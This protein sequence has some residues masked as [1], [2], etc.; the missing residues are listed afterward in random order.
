[1]IFR[2]ACS[3]RRYA[4]INITGEIGINII[5]CRIHSLQPVH[6]IT[7]H[8]DMQIVLL[9]HNIDE[10]KFPYSLLVVAAMLAYLDNDIIAQHCP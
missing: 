1:M 6:H 3:A 8:K 7:H 10:A 2:A 9:H 4:D 5:N